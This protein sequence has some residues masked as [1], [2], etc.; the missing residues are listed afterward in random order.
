MQEPSRRFVTRR[1]GVALANAEGIPVTKSRVDKDSMKGVGPEPVARFGPMDL[2][3]PDTFLQY[4]RALIRP[5]DKPEATQSVSPSAAPSTA[6]ATSG[7]ASS[8]PCSAS[9]AVSGA[10]SH[11]IIPASKT[12]TAS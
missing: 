5:I 11:P 7:R 6:T 8:S 9:N 12:E 3:V 2:Y 1:Q 10:V 4:A